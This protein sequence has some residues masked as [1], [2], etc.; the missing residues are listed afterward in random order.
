LPAA[1]VVHLGMADLLYERDDL[2]G[3]ERALRRGV[4]LAERSGEASTLVWAYVAL[5]RTKRAR[6]DEDGAL[7]MARKAER[8]A[9]VSGADLQI[10]IAASWM[11]RLRLMRGDL[12]QAVDIERERAANADGAADAARAVDRM[13]TARLLH[14]RGRHREALR[15]LEGLRE[16]AAAEGRARDLVEILVLRASAQWASNRKEWAVSTL[17][18]ALDLAAPEGYVRTFVDEGAPLAALLSEVLEARQRGRTDSLRRVPAHYPRRLLAVL[19]RDA[20]PAASS[21]AGLSDPLTRRE[22]EVLRLMASGKS[23]RGI[24]SELF[25]GV[26]TV[27]THANNIYRKLGAHSRTQATARARELG[28]I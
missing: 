24:S 2:D 14:A 28:L 19:G 3:A 27:K 7:E 6:G 4:D 10:A 18:E 26:G 1:G 11:A 15:L 12:A 17:A 8:I 22:L 21:A 5:S 20:A 9:R 16:A 23:N 25:V 13:T